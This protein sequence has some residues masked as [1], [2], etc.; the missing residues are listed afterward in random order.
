MNV[1]HQLTALSFFCDNAIST[2][3][4]RAEL[5]REFYDHYT[6]Q[7]GPEY[8][9]K[10]INLDGETYVLIDDGADEWLG[11]AS[12]YQKQL[13]EMVD[14]ILAGNHDED[15]S[16]AETYEIICNCE[17]YWSKLGG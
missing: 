16:H 15:S 9:V 6:G 1:S 3:D 17:C 4:K 5:A 11:L 7:S 13:D 14:S 2:A 10:M 12:D 8:A